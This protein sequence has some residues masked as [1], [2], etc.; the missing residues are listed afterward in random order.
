MNGV[1]ENKSSVV[2]ENLGSRSIT[3][4]DVANFDEQ[5]LKRVRGQ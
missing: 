1:I 5:D 4:S 3:F 2:V